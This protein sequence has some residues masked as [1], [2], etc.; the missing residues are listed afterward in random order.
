MC[1][2]T[3]TSRLGMVD[4]TCPHC[5]CE[6]DDFQTVQRA[7]EI[8]RLKDHRVACKRAA[9]RWLEVLYEALVAAVPNVLE[10]GLMHAAASWLEEGEHKEHA[11]A[12]RVIANKAQAAWNR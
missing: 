6:H 7:L 12:L 1:V 2:S 9:S 4:V 5:H 3:V 10:T 11:Q 8:L